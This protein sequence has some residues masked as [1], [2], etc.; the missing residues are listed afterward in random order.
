MNKDLSWKEKWEEQQNESESIISDKLDWINWV[1]SNFG[2]S[3]LKANEFLF[4]LKVNLV[5]EDFYQEGNM[6]KLV[7]KLD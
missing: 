2:S 4:Y 7:F 5:T 6:L 1:K 3:A